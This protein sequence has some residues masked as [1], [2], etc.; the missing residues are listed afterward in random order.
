[1]SMFKNL[2]YN[3]GLTLIEILVALMIFSTVILIV[4]NLTLDAIR[5]EAVST[6]NQVALD[7]ARFIFQRIAKALRIS[8]V[9]TLAT[10]TS[11]IIELE[12]PTRG[13]VS[14]FLSSEN[15]IVERIDNN[16]NTDSFL[17]SSTV[18]IEGFSF[19]IKGS[20]NGTDGRQPQVTLSLKIKPPKAKD[21]ELTSLVFQTT[22]SQR[23]L[24]LSSACQA[25]P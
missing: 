19:N 14:Y 11:S 22:I 23:C 17:D 16:S 1:M 6:S 4:A 25:S 8:I 7:N 24:D 21:R 2:K 12:H 3:H 15:H 9:K 18:T 13:I 5:A 20:D 10:T